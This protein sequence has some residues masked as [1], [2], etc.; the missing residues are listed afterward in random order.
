MSTLSSPPVSPPVV[1]DNLETQEATHTEINPGVNTTQQKKKKKKKKSKANKAAEA[2]KAVPEERPNVICISRNKHWKYISSYHVRSVSQL[3]SYPPIF[4]LLL[5]GP[6]LQLPVELL[7]S[8]MMLNQ[9]PGTVATE[10]RSPSTPSYSTAS[11]SKPKIKAANPRGFPD[12]SEF[13]PP[14]TPKL[15]ISTTLPPPFPPPVPGKPTPPP[16]DP[17]VFRS[18]TSIRRLIDEAAELSVRASSGMSSAELNA[19][20]NGGG[21]SGLSASPWAAA[22]SLGLNPLGLP[23]GTGR[24]VAMSAVRVHRLRTL[25]VAKLAQA[26]KQDEI[27][28]SVMVMQGGSVFDDVAER[29]LKHGGLV[30]D[31]SDPY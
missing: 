19:M 23:N 20:R 1:T 17:G 6:W 18:V 29:V 25:A 2:A 12:L 3:E 21:L 13:T 27:A 31:A 8:L 24:N 14:D 10:P 26:Y 9:D 7:E 4:I 16:V 30:H 22:Q 11:P 5:K 28:S 15:I